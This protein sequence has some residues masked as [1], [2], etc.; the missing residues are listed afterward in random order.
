MELPKL[1]GKELI[2]FLLNLKIEMLGR[3]EG[4]RAG[5]HVGK[6]R[7]GI[8]ITAAYTL[9]LAGIPAKWKAARSTW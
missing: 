5:L 6:I 4:E 8:Y 7:K 9:L 3:G 1:T 2:S